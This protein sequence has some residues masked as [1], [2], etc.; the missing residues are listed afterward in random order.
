MATII[1]PKE[2]YKIIGACISVHNNLGPGFYEAVY[3]EAL[4]YEFGMQHIPFTKQPKLRI[5][6]NDIQLGKYYIADFVCY[7]FI[8]LEIKATPIIYDLQKYQLLNYLK[9]TGLE[10]GILINFGAKSLNYKRIVNTC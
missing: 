7:D 10:L 9:A 3:Q 1:Y 4:E 2:S 5:R 6:Y 8:L